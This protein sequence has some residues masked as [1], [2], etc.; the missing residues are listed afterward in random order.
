MRRM[1]VAV[2]VSALALAG[3]A[4]AAKPPKPAS[5]AVTISAS[6]RTVLF[7]STTAITGQA[8]GNKSAGATVELQEQKSAGQFATVMSATADST[9]HYTFKVAPT[10]N[11]AYR[12]LAHTAPQ[13]TSP[14][15]TVKV[16]V[17]VTLGVSTT[18][19]KAGSKVRFFGFVLPAYNGKFVQI[20]RR[21]VSGWK[22]VARKAL[23]A[24]T[25]VAGV[26]RSKY[27][28]RLLIRASGTYRAYF[29]PSDGLRQPNASS[30]KHLRVH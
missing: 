19:P 9:G 14:V 18:T 29:N 7:G 8:T 25:P 2:F 17:K 1:I 3:P 28:L 26:A 13:A 16:L 15:T 6:P 22:T 20:Q 10:Q 23:V 5:S 4:L 24:A 12:V 27:S 30:L 11:T 21:T